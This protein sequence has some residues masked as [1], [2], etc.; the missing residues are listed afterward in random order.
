MCGIW[1]FFGSRHPEDRLVDI[2]HR[3][4]DGRGIERFRHGE[5]E[6]EMAHWRLSILDLTSRSDQPLAYRGGR[7]QVI[8]NGEIYNY[9]ELRAELRAAGYEF[10]S[11][12]DTEVIPAAYDHWGEDCLAHFRGMFAFCL[13]DREKGVLFAARDRFG[14]KPLYCFVS[15]RGVALASEIK[16]FTGLH[17]FQARA[18]LQR[19]TEF[20][21]Y[22]AQ[23]HT[24]ETMWAGV[25]QLRGGQ[26]VTLDAK[27]WQPR[28]ALPIRRWYEL[29]PAAPFAGTFEEAVEKYR[30]I[31]SET[32]SLH[33][34]SD[35]PVGSC[36]SG[37]MDSSAI[38]CAMNGLL[39]AEGRGE[40]Q[41]TFSCCFDE[42][43]CDERPFMRAVEEFTGAHPHHITPRGE[44]ALAALET[45]IWHQ[46]EPVNNATVFSQFTLFQ[47][48]KAA[49]VKVM[50]DGQGGDEQLASYPQFFGPHLLGM[51]AR[52]RFAGARHE[53]RRFRELH[54]WTLGDTAKSL[55]FWFGPAWLA[56]AKNRLAPPRRQHAWL[57][58]DAL[59]NRSLTLGPPWS[60]QPGEAAPVTTQWL[61][62]MMLTVTTLPMLLHWEDRNSMAHSIEARVP[63]LDHRLI[64]F[65]LSLPDEFKT[66]DGITKRILKAAMR[67]AMPAK[68]IERTDKKGFATPEEHWLRA[69]P[70]GKFRAAILET[71]HAHPGIFS[72]SGTEAELRLFHERRKP[73]SN[74]FWRILT[75]GVWARRFGVQC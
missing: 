57:A 60:R 58:W 55:L 5:T 14:I 63:F 11:D 31:F 51:L 70:S 26:C 49:G 28:A 46:D 13:W 67:D 43:E 29:R 50:L 61:S 8:F 34:R 47:T 36:L 12:G 25:R 41:N 73:F 66:Q 2:P 15:E 37:G 71:A 74:L 7:Y 48:V 72:P 42:P 21:A 65:T 3:G 19:V 27:T 52:G 62:R 59:E 64:E 35:V 56:T 1:C 10:Q 24:D 17:G 40:I 16:Q 30:E 23:D 20:L 68:V 38:V 33:L 53:T 45:M 9:R 32:V 69:D 39:H 18:N 54:G 4:P 22:G 75:F 6:V 44:D